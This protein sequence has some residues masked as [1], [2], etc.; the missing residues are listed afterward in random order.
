MSSNFWCH[1]LEVCYKPYKVLIDC[2]DSSFMEPSLSSVSSFRECYILSNSSFM[3]H[4]LPFPV[5]MFCEVFTSLALVKERVDFQFRDDSRTMVMLPNSNGS[6]SESHGGIDVIRLR[7][8]FIYLSLVYVLRV[9]MSTS[10]FIS[11]M[12]VSLFLRLS[13]PLS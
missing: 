4:C 8:R 7:F 1:C 9:A 2:H 13:S 6:F 5:S 11:M 3:E 12:S 10:S